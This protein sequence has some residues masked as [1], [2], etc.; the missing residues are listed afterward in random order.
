MFTNAPETWRQFINQRIRWS[1]GLVE[2]FKAHWPLLFKPRLTTLFIWFNILFPYL[3]LVYTFAFVPGLILACFGI[4]YIAGPITFLLVPMALLMNWI[5][6]RK[7][8]AIIRSAGI[9]VSN[10]SLFF[11]LYAMFY[12]VVLQPACVMGYIK[13]LVRGGVKNWGTK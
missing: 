13:E 5:S 9:R 4:Y 11:V 12:S 2:A 10:D 1:R 6:Y 3:D 8:N 7:Q